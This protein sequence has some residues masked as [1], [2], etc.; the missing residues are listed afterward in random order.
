MNRVIQRGIAMLVLSAVL[1]AC[2][3][4]KATPAPASDSGASAPTSAPAAK[5]TGVPA[6]SAPA[7][8]LG[9]VL[10]NKGE[11]ITLTIGG[12]G[13][14]AGSHE[15]TSPEGACSAGLTGESGWG[16]QYSITTSDPKQFSSLQLIANTPDGGNTTT[17]FMTT[18]SFGE[19][20]SASET[21]YEIKALGGESGAGSGTVTIEDRG[22]TATITIK[23]ETA[24]G[25]PIEARIDCLS[26]LRFS[27][28]GDSDGPAAPANGIVLTISGGDLAGSYDFSPSSDVSTCGAGPENSSVLAES[29]EDGQKDN[30][31]TV[32]YYDE[33]SSAA[34]HSLQLLV[35]DT[36]VGASK[37]F[38]LDINYQTYY[39]ENLSG[40]GDLGT[41][42]VDD[43][44]DSATI[45]IKAKT[46][47]G[48]T[49]SGTIE[50]NSV[51]R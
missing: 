45:T 34:I 40:S 25:T 38:Y 2:G 15:V 28:S 36:S 49:I 46:E 42:T 26:V 8:G 44:G 47:S 39:L 29:L 14:N 4:E 12:S 19:L 48:D 22:E 27:G 20:F 21:Q 37:Q 41:I 1:M 3:S 23:G 30:N 32:D 18:I 10:N 7:S 6:T 13:P 17:D 9:D 31:F 35:A 33:K 16:N 11:K 50:C 51:E 43:R 24:D 5:P